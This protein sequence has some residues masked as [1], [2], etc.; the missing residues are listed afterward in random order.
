[1]YG[2]MCMSNKALIC[3]KIQN[4]LIRYLTENDFLLMLKWLTDKRIL[5]FYDGRDVNYTMESL[6]EH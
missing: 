3:D 4:I 6:A 1:M 2:W 5:E